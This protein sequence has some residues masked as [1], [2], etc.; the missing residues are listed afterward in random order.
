MRHF[1]T[2]GREK[3][4]IKKSLPNLDD[5]RTHKVI[6][7]LESDAIV[8]DTANTGEHFIVDIYPDLDKSDKDTGDGGHVLA[9]IV[10]I[11]KIV[12]QDYQD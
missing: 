4:G 6:L 11:V 3:R 9:S 1:W 12:C 7:E 10:K 5:G 8:G 2:D